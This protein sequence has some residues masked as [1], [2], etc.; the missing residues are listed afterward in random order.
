MA[1]AI[2]LVASIVALAGAGAKIAL[3][4]Y[5]VAD[6]I[7]SAGKEARL[8][9]TEVSLFSQSLNAVSKSLGR[10][11]GENGCLKEIARVVTK[12]CESLLE[13]LRSLLTELLSL[14]RSKSASYCKRIKWIF[15]KPKVCAIRAS[16]E[17]F[18]ATLILLVAT[19]DSA[20]AS[21]KNAPE[22]I[23]YVFVLISITR[24]HIL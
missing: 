7:G 24:T 15:K 11:S 21:Y 10:S 8:I 12:A 23:M 9:A 18:K 19:M 22:F 6:S 4:L 13:E 3:T 20:E 14:P 1:E 5:D 17:S 2:G 16:I